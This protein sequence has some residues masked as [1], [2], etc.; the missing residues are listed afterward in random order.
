VASL[1]NAAASTTLPSTT[2]K[3]TV[4]SL[5]QTIRNCLRSIT[6]TLSG[7]GTL[8]TKSTITSED[9]TDG[10]ITNADISTTAA[11]APTKLATVTVAKGGTGETTVFAARTN[12]TA[13]RLVKATQV[14]PTLSYIIGYNSYS[15]PLIR[16]GNLFTFCLTIQTT[17]TGAQ[18]FTNGDTI[19]K[20][21]PQNDAYRPFG[22]NVAMNYATSSGISCSIKV[23]SSGVI[24]V[25]AAQTFTIS[26]GI[27]MIFPTIVL[28]AKYQLETHGFSA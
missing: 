5:L 22:N 6:E 13:G 8:A 15:A 2:A 28:P 20:L 4:Q 14:A 1:T 16:V 17:S 25:A 7:L 21:T 23:D 3:S 26:A 24:I 12:L 19:I 27:W 11:I 18:T 10:T 9:I